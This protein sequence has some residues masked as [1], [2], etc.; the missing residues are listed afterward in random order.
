RGRESDLSIASLNG[1]SGVVLSGR[2]DAVEAAARALSGPGVRTT[3]LAVSNAF[4]SPL[5]DPALEAFE[6]EGRSIALHPPKKLLVSNLL[7]R[8]VGE[9]V[10]DP[11]YWRRHL[12]EPVRFGEGVLALLA[13]RCDTF[14]E[15]GAGT[16]LLGMARLVKDDDAHAWLPSV[17]GRPGGKPALLA[18]PPRPLCPR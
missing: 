17:A 15:V 13:A 18:S 3:A 16:T 5:M 8:P 9:E 6:R 14:V 10:T 11:A 7:G 2:R 12:R 1:P 4:H